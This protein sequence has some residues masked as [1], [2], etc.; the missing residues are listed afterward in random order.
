MVAM[1][2]LL[3][4]ILDPMTIMIKVVGLTVFLIFVKISLFFIVSIYYSG[5]F[6]VE[7]SLN[8]PI[9]NSK[10]E[11]LYISLPLP[12]M[13]MARCCD[14]TTTSEYASADGEPGTTSGGSCIT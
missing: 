14:A 13:P 8:P 5:W 11:L 4:K 6:L 9:S 10:V 7:A 3:A 2:T 12:T 1:G